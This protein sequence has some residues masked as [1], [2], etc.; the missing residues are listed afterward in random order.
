MI[1]LSKK[2]LS[3]LL[4]LLLWS[5]NNFFN[6]TGV[7]R[8]NKGNGVT[9][10]GKTMQTLSWKNNNAIIVSTNIYTVTNKSNHLTHTPFNFNPISRRE[11][12]DV[13]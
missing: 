3:I 2:F 6:L 11:I 9:P 8:E 5:P 13:K 10:T 7:N 4:I 12:R 1:P